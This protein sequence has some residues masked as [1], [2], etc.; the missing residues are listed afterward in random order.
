MGTP[1]RKGGSY[2]MVIDQRWQTKD[3]ATLKEPFFKQ[4]VVTS[5]DAESP[6][7]SSWRIQTPASETVQPLI[8]VF[9]EPLDYVLLMEAIF[10]EGPKGSVVAGKFQIEKEEKVLHF[11]PDHPWLPGLYS[12]V[13][14]ARLEDL[15]G[16]NLY[17][18]F[19]QEITA[20]KTTTQEESYWFDFTIN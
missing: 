11:I 10:V 19:D 18:L 8:I 6:K 1:L 13:C 17:R 12:V 7:L 3:G 15:A 14:E 20:Q 9:T 5:R 16:N 4:F 2:T